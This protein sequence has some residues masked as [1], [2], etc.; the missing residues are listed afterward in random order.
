MTA[1]TV[2][3][4][5]IQF[6]RGRDG[7][8]DVPRIAA[9]VAAADIV[10]WQEVTQNWQR[11]GGLDQALEL[12]RAL[13]HH[14]AFGTGFAVDAGGPSGA[15][16]RWRTFGNMVS[17]RWPIRSTRTLLLPKR[18]LAGVF[19]LQ[20]SVTEAVVR[21][22]GGDLR[23]YSVHLSHISPG[24]RLPQVA[25]L[26]DFVA[27]APLNGSA[28][29]DTFTPDWTEGMDTPF[30]PASALVMGDLNCTADSAEYAMLCGERHPK[31]G[32]LVPRDGLHDLWVA[33]GHGELD[34]DTCP[35]EQRK[36]DHILGTADLAGTV[37]RAWIDGEAAGSDHQPLFVTLRR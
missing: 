5:N 10:A 7:V 31:R 2:A 12:A 14:H 20:R 35:A 4:Y 16:A 28:W 17:S 27:D 30:L 18:S 6:G 13:D 33:A 23:V 15:P 37:E 19:D 9:A 1:L 26:R 32:R 21:A 8:Y 34:G 24:Q 11:G 22:P 25:M 3:T 36:I 29:D